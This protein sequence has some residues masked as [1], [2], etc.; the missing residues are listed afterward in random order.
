MT[1]A[2]MF[3]IFFPNSPFLLPNILIVEDIIST[4]PLLGSQ[5]SPGCKVFLLGTT[6]CP[7]QEKK[8][9]P[10]LFHQPLPFLS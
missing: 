6:R 9:Q 7:F 5:K 3:I 8:T 4:Y 10:F 1:M 2:M